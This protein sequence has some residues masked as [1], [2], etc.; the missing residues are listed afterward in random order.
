ML[1]KGHKTTLSLP[2]FC[3]NE[4]ALFS[5][6][7]LE[8][9]FQTVCHIVLEDASP[10]PDPQQLFGDTEGCLGNGAV[11]KTQS[12]CKHLEW[13]QIPYF[14]ALSIRTNVAVWANKCFPP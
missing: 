13:A 8:A 5:L 10:F 7:L 3:K 12:I 1:P 14:N 11:G 2:I 9:S 4:A 6:S